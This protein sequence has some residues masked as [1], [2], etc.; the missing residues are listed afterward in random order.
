MIW[1]RRDVSATGV[2]G[3]GANVAATPG[4][5]IPRDSKMNILK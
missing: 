1:K 5:Q 3:G 2:V 4:Q